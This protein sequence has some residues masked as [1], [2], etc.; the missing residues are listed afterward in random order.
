MNNK[1][2]IGTIETLTQSLIVNN[3]RREYISKIYKINEYIFLKLTLQPNESTWKFNIESYD[4]NIIHIPFN[5]MTHL[6][7]TGESDF[8]KAFN[9]AIIRSNTYFN[10]LKRIA[11]LS[12]ININLNFTNEER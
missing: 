5:N 7:D 4:R 11:S 2:K 1:Q 3:E 8:D 6:V 12:H 10:N 9:V